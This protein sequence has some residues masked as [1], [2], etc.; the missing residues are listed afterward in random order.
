MKTLEEQRAFV[1]EHLAA[2]AVHARAA[3]TAATVLAQK[4]AS[5]AAYCDFRASN[6]EKMSDLEIGLLIRDWEAGVAADAADQR[7]RR[8]FRES[9]DMTIRY[10]APPP[11]VFAAEI[12]K[13]EEP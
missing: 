4:H 3:S 2:Q 7:A 12:E 11:V 10:L 6:V 8:C 1:R 9:L 13:K 5:F